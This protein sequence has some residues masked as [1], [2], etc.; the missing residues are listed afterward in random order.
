METT[1]TNKEFE[2]YQRIQESIYKLHDSLDCYKTDEGKEYLQLLENKLGEFTLPTIKQKDFDGGVI[3]YYF[4]CYDGRGWRE[5]TEGVFEMKEGEFYFGENG[6]IDVM[7]IYNGFMEE[8]VITNNI[9]IGEWEL[10]VL[11][12]KMVFKSKV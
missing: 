7:E 11:E 9:N 6:E 1:Y 3:E 2:E 10:E 8:S 5:D 4:D 12:W